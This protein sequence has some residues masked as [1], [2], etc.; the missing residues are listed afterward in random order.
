M[1]YFEFWNKCPKLSELKIRHMFSENSAIGRLITHH[2]MKTFTKL[3]VIMK[4]F[5]V[6][7]RFSA[8]TTPHARILRTYH[9][10]ITDL[11][12]MYKLMLYNDFKNDPYL[13]VVLITTSVVFRF[14]P[15]QPLLRAMISITP[16]VI[17]QSLS[18]VSK[19]FHQLIRRS[20]IQKWFDNW[21]CQQ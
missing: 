14:R 18:G 6:M 5:K 10:K 2:I 7:G 19:N 11:K 17:I 21:K 13:N 16:M 20:Q 12:S 1:A 8:T 3:L 4:W 9:L 15:I